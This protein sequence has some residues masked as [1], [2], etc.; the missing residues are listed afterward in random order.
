MKHVNLSGPASK[1]TGLVTQTKSESM[2]KT[3]LITGS[4]T[5]IGL[6]TAHYF[7]DRGWNVVATMRNPDARANDLK[8]K[9][10]VEIANLDVLDRD[11][12]R[13]AVQFARNN[14]G[15]IDV[16]VNNAGYAL[17]GV[18][19]ATTPEKTRRQLDTNVL[20][21]MDVTREIIPV[22]RK[23]GH[24]VIVNVTSI[25][26][27]VAS[28]LHSV[29]QGS[30]F[31][32]EGFSESLFYELRP[33]NIKVKIV[34][35]GVI[36]T[37]FY[38]RSMD[39]V[40]AEGLESYRGFVKRISEYDARLTAGGSTPEVVAECIFH[41]VND[42]SWRLRYHAGKYSGLILGLRRLLPDRA[43]MRLVCRR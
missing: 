7:A 34:E 37:D 26:G 19:E 33:Q 23:Q 12:I 38:G 5:G 1:R 41:A 31:A 8:G 32:V 6:A 9:K 14:F 36:K 3:V 30:K 27:R 17:R 40:D 24:G 29:Y 39:R 20:G 28:P 35:P 18:F 25:A 13:S 2:Q 21:L 42:R 4:S 22:M 15:T 11:S 43:M 16:L 10:N